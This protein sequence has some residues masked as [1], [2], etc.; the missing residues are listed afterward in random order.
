MAK[1]QSHLEE[2]LNSLSHGI[3]VGLSAIGLVFLIDLAVQ[4]G[5]I[6]RIIAFSIYGVTLLLL[7]LASTLYHG[8]KSPRTKR[9]LRICDHASIYLLIAG[10]YTPFCLITMPWEWGRLMLCILWPIAIVG[11][12]FKIFW[13][14]RFE[15]LSTLLYIGMG[16]MTL[17]AIKPLFTGLSLAGFLLLGTGG[18]FY[19][20]GTIFF[21]LDHIPF[22]HVIWHLFVMSGSVCHFF[23]VFLYVAPLIKS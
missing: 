22:N 21:T 19:T 15:L 4:S 2:F 23:T 5:D 10:S 12:I 20:F 7:Y 14:D 11:I 13:V 3:G 8:A 18:L 9:I 16:W 17:I 6:K 1:Q